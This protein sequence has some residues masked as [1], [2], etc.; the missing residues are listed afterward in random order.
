MNSVILNIFGIVVCG[1][2]G[3][4]AGWAFV[5]WLGMEGTLGAIVA[6]LIGTVIATAG[7]AAVTALL[8]TQGWI[9]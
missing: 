2:L 6:A 1:G 3:G 5:T 8:R 7:F 4:F 9:R